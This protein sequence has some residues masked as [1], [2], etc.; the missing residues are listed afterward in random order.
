MPDIESSLNGAAALIAAMKGQTRRLAEMSDRIV[1]TLRAGNRVLT[2]GNGGSA[3][4]ALHLAEEMV[5]RFS[6]PRRALSA[7]CLSADPTALTC[8]A[9]DWEYAEVFARQ[10]DA[11][12]RA[13]D[14]L[15]ALSTSGKSPSILRAL[16]RARSRG[17][18]TLGLLGP[19][20]SPAEKLC[21]LCLTLDGH[22]AAR[23]QEGH[24]VAIH[25]F[26]E[27]IDDEFGDEATAR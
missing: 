6:R 23:V 24:L 21:D 17:L 7:L 18:G 25:L 27:R 22:S 3:A 20:G 26:L 10:V 8:I 14:L 1:A 4:E 5:G 11:H 19:G 2:C 13:G 16:E 12:G 9:N 15:I